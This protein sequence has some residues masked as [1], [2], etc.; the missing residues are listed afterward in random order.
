M[1]YQIVIFARPATAVVA[2]RCAARV[3]RTVQRCEPPRARE[4]GGSRNR[5][6][7][8][9]RLTAQ[10]SFSE[11]PRPGCGRVGCCGLGDAERWVR[12]TGADRLRRATTPRVRPALRGR[13]KVSRAA[14]LAV[15]AAL[16]PAT[17]STPPAA[18]CRP[19][20]SAWPPT[21]GVARYAPS[22]ARMPRCGCWGS[23]PEVLRGR[24]RTRVERLAS[25]RVGDRSRYRGW[26]SVWA[27]HD[28]SPL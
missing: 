10:R 14:V 19:T 11:A 17:P 18:H 9:R 15:A 28:G 12:F 21:L 23:R 13:I 26:A 2:R 4:R 16:M 6:R 20:N 24:Q 25:W 27:L 1:I 3:A 22:S 8:R 7:R 5:R